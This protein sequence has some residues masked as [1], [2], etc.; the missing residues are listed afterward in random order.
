ME[1]GYLNIKDKKDEKVILDGE[2]DKSILDF[3]IKS[4]NILEEKL[5]EWSV[6]HIDKNIFEDGKNFEKFWKKIKGR[7]GKKAAENFLVGIK[8]KKIEK[9][10]L[11]FS[12]I[13]LFRSFFYNKTRKEGIGFGEGDQI[14]F[15]VSTQKWKAVRKINFEK[16]TLK[17]NVVLFFTNLFASLERKIEEK[18]HKFFGKEN[19]ENFLKDM[20]KR[21]IGDFKDLSNVKEEI[22]EFLD[23]KIQKNLEFLANFIIFVLLY[24]KGFKILY[25]EAEQKLKIPKG[26]KI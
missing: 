16:N 9:L 13:I 22:K 7:E 3:C 15:Y 6:N 24:K 20:E 19:F 14:V 18:L 1:L 17:K 11:V 5:L 2:D 21:K 26:T 23:G 10:L 4:F 25:K 12:K 8:D